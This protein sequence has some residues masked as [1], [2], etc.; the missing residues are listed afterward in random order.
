MRF[1]VDENLPLGIVEYLTA[2]GHDVLDIA[3]SPFRGLSDKALWLKAAVEDRTIITRDLDFPVIGLKPYPHS[4]ILLRVPPSFTAH[5]ITELF[6]LSLSKINLA[7]IRNKI[8]VVSPGLARMGA[9][10]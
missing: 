4:R 5:Q 2:Q 10:R 7:I 9:F 8:V 6:I 3:A 1:L